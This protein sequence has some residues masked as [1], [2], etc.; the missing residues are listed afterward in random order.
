MHM[1]KLWIFV[2]MW[3]QL[4]EDVLRLHDLLHYEVMFIYGPGRDG[5]IGTERPASV[6]GVLWCVVVLWD[7]RL[8]WLMR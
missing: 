1:Q 7:P 8:Y 3:H 4:A 2:A 6:C 5:Y